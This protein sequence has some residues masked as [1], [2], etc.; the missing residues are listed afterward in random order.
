MFRNKKIILT[1]TIDGWTIKYDIDASN[2]ATIIGNTVQGN[3]SLTIPSLIPD[4]LY[5]VKAISNSAFNN[6]NTL[7]NITIPSSVTSIGD[8]TFVG[9]SLLESV[10]FLGNIPTIGTNNFGISG[11]TAYIIKTNAINTSILP[12]YFTTIN[13]SFTVN[14]WKLNYVVDSNNNATITKYYTV[15]D[16]TLTIP[17]II[18]DTLYN[19]I[20]IG[21]SAFQNCT[22]LSRV[23]IPSSVTTINNSAFSNCTLLTKV[24]F[25][26]DIPIIA[27]NNFEITGDTAYHIRRAKNTDRLTMFTYKQTYISENENLISNICFPANTP[28]TTNQGII[29]IHKI[30]PEIHTIR[31]KKIVAITKTVSQDKHLV[32]FEKNS[33]G[34]NVPCEKTFMTKHHLVFYKGEMVHAIDFVGK[35]ENVKKVKYTGEIL[36]NVLMEDYEKMVVNNL[37]CETLHPE[38][39]I[40]KV[41]NMLKD[42]SPEKQQK[43]IKAVNEY[44]IK[45]K[46]YSKSSDKLVK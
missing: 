13:Y 46:V 16:A 22:S 14:G 2:N 4:T 6:C 41:Y 34:N 42:L 20:V 39:S 35:I 44:A 5:N 17:S 3:D 45:N 31:N 43:L 7:K 23:N 38:N 25:E 18:P 40:A 36:Y 19:V 29:P 26:G 27:G 33:L 1:F 8:T 12:S 11:D 15:G 9:C 24:Y 28:I 30:N 32:C 21:N 10:Y 37:I